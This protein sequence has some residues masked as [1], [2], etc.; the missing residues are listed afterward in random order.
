MSLQSATQ[1][2]AASAGAVLSSQLLG[3]AADG[4]LV[5]MEKVT[6]GAMVASLA[7]PPL[8]ARV[9][10]TV[11]AGPADAAPPA[12]PG[13]QQAPGGPRPAAL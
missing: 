2:L 8:L 3:E 1:H 4:R 12:G 5:G 7:L 13:A 11:R 9:A 6:A 10:R